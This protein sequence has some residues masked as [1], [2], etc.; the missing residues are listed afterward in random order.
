MSHSALYD[1]RFRLPS[2]EPS[3]PV[4]PAISSRRRCATLSRDAQ[5][6]MPTADVR[7]TNQD[8]SG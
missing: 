3:T 4:P 2:R 5:A 6:P 1:E 8:R 7:R